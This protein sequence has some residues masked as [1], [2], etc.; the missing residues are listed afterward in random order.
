MRLVKYLLAFALSTNYLTMNAQLPKQVDL[1]ELGIRFEIPDGW[2]GGIQGDYILLGHE[3]L[4]GMMLLLQNQST[5]AKELKNLAEQGTEEDGV[6]LKPSSEFKVVNNKR[7][8]GYYEGQY[9]GVDVKT[10]AVGLLNDFGSGLSLLIMTER[11]KFSNVHEQE[12]EKLLKT[13]RFSKPKRENNGE[14]QF[15][16]D[17][18]VG[19]TLKYMFTKSS[20]DFNGGSSG[21]NESRTVS[22]CDNG[23]F[24][25]FSS[26]NASMDTGTNANRYNNAR[27][28]SNGNYEIYAAQ[29]AVWLNLS[30]DNAEVYTVELTTDDSGL[31]TFIDGAR[32]MLDGDAECQ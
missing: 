27:T 8:Q 5:T 21:Y 22:L 15:W 14:V 24:L 2:S 1:P 30:F 28:N 4:P 23:R 16:K 32:Y 10:Y 26:A 11:D 29:N 25:Y 20:H 18:L 3:T 17:R 13:V 12:A 9:D 6:F 7:V 31:K 19:K